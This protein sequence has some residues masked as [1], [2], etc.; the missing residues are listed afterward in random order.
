MALTVL[1]VGTVQGDVRS[2]VIGR[3]LHI[4]CAALREAGA[5]GAGWIGKEVGLLLGGGESTECGEA[6]DEALTEH[7]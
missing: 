2:R 1:N 6:Q 7:I 5:I 4:Q 3:E